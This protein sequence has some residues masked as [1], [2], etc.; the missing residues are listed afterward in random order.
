MG[1]TVGP[2]AL[3]DE[4]LENLDISGQLQIRRLNSTN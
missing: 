3:D 2:D 1:S 4:T